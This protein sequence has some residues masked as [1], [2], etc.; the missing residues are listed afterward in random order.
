[1]IISR[2]PL[3]VSFAGGGSDLHAF[4]RHEPGAVFTTAIDKYIYITVNKKF[5][6]KIRASYSVTYVPPPGLSRAVGAYCIRPCPSH[7]RPSS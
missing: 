4:Y 7:R 1:V 6:H 3:R 2:T 5:D